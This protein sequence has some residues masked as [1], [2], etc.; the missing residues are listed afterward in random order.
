MDIQFNPPVSK[1][2]SEKK[3]YDQEPKEEKVI[4]RII[5]KIVEVEKPII[6]EKEKLITVT[7]TEVKTEEFYKLLSESNSSLEKTKQMVKEAMDQIKY[8]ASDPNKLKSLESLIQNQFS[9]TNSNFDSLKGEF[10]KNIASLSVRLEELKPYIDKVKTNGS[11]ESSSYLNSINAVI[12]GIKTDLQSL[13]KISEVQQYLSLIKSSIDKIQVNPIVTVTTQKIEDTETKEAIKKFN[14]TIL[15]LKEV[16]S[17]R[18]RGFEERLTILEAF[19]QPMV[20]S[21]KEKMDKTLEVHVELANSL[22][23]DVI[24]K[25][26]DSAIPEKIIYSTKTLINELQEQYKVKANIVKDEVISSLKVHFENN[27]EDINRVVNQKIFDLSLQLK[28]IVSNLLQEEL[29]K[30]LSNLKVDIPPI[31]VQSNDSK[32]QVLSLL[33]VVK[34]TIRVAF[35]EMKNEV[36]VVETLKDLKDKIGKPGQEAL[37]KKHPYMFFFNKSVWFK[38]NGQ[39]WYRV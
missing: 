20:P 5:E 17:T 21:L 26:N 15:S 29:T 37:V 25:F 8:I 9:V 4:E 11:Q 35:L 19:I 13:S 2:K 16:I 10:N 24:Q 1:K 33:G 14:E 36:I 28:D 39:E 6:V 12:S 27:N 32:E 34:Q 3:D 38:S 22:A 7:N 30:Y 18:I 31:T 23:S